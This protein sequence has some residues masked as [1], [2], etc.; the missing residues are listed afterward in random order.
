[1]KKFLLYFKRVLALFI[2]GFFALVALDWIVG[3]FAFCMGSPYRG[4]FFAEVWGITQHLFTWM[5]KQTLTRFILGLFVAIITF[6]MPILVSYLSFKWFDRSLI[7]KRWE[8]LWKNRVFLYPI[9]L[10]A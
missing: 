5:P 2:C 9:F 6:A 3:L 10:F 7:K 4:A 8:T 1:M